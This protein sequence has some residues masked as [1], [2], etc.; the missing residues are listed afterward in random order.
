M[1]ALRKGLWSVPFF[2]GD[3]AGRRGVLVGDLLR[4][5]CAEVDRRVVNS[6]AQGEKIEQQKS[7]TPEVRSA[8]LVTSVKASSLSAHQS[9]FLR[10]FFV[11][12]QREFELHRV[13]LHDA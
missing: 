13:A 7:W 3:S 1:P 9:E 5:E 6:G 10:R 2:F 11:V 12:C 4:G 8:S